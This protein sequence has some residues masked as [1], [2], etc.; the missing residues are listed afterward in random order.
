MHR[1]I[2]TNIKSGLI[3]A[4]AIIPVMAAF[5]FLTAE[6]A[7]ADEAVIN[8]RHGHKLVSYECVDY[9][10]FVEDF[11]PCTRKLPKKHRSYDKKE[12]SE[13]AIE[14]DT[15]GNEREV[16]EFLTEDMSLNSAAACGVMTNIF[17]ESTFRPSA[18]NGSRCMGIVQWTATRYDDL[19]SWC[20]ENGED[21]E[22]LS[23][24]LLFLKEELTNTYSSVY[25]RLLSVE[26]S[27]EGA[28]EAAYW[29]C[30]RFEVPYETEKQSKY[31]ANLCTELYWPMYG[32]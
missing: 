26:D 25:D 24:Q 8:R 20:E 15:S 23:S 4:F 19:M 14:H 21:A 29:F 6:E 9:S 5:A 13:E 10:G 28:Y 3:V 32:D 27:S 11:G 17:C 2:A 31:R 12:F 22:T 30:K 7:D 18:T 16:Y 1:S